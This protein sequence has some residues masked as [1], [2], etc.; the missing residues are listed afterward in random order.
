MFFKK[1]VWADFSKNIF[2]KQIG[3]I[4]YY[5]NVPGIFFKVI[6]FTI[7]GFERCC[8][9][10]KPSFMIY[11]K[12]I[13]CYNQ[14]KMLH[15]KNIDF[16]QIHNFL[17]KKNFG[18]IGNVFFIRIE[19]KK[20]ILSIKVLVCLEVLNVRPPNTLKKLAKCFIIH[21]L[22]FQECFTKICWFVQYKYIYIY[23][24]FYM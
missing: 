8:P 9:S 22:S 11:I 2:L 21:F 19:R 15:V 3:S 24:F 7:V 12:K 13:L 4:V 14:F 20:N 10:I 5:L 6:L 17:W 23:I 18:I 1:S 16:D